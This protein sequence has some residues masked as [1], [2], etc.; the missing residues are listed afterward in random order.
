MSQEASQGVMAAPAEI[1]RA[2]CRKP[3]T[4][5]SRSVCCSVSRYSRGGPSCVRFRSV[6]A[7][8]HDQCSDCV[9]ALSSKRRACTTFGLPRTP[10][11]ALF[12][13]ESAHELAREP[14]TADHTRY[15][16]LQN[17]EFELP[18]FVQSGNWDRERDRNDGAF[19]RAKHLV[20]RTRVAAFPRNRACMRHCSEHCRHR[21]SAEHT[22][23]D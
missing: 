11:S 10:P 13:F 9:F 22:S 14:S 18:L 8:T 7:P 16:P 2:S 3:N 23:T 5:R 15:N 19:G 6:F 21:S 20:F 1:L 17:R 12:G 4:L